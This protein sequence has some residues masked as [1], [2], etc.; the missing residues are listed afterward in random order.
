MWERQAALVKPLSGPV[1]YHLDQLYEGLGAP[2]F[3]GLILDAGCGEGIDLAN[4]ALDARCEVVGLESSHGGVAA[5]LA[6]IATLQRAHLVQGD[7]LKA[8]LAD[9]LFDGAHCYGVVHHT[10]DPTRAMKELSRVLKQGAQL[11]LYVYED[12]SDRARHW[13][14]AL[15]AVNSLRR[16]TTRCPPRVMMTFCK[17]LSPVVYATCTV[18]SKRFSWAS[19]LPY[20]HGRHA[21]GLGGDL[22]D[23][24]SAPIE[25]RYSRA[26]ALELPQAAGLK[27]RRIVQRRGWMIWAEKP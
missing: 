12:F 10:I 7:L 2:R 9:G 21:W 18:P 8:P 26:S 14:A 13:R 5:S 25:R 15:R 6:R 1:P 27:V 4:L 20:S 19:R 17:L 11:L 22:Y 16:L 24:F 23:R 3:N